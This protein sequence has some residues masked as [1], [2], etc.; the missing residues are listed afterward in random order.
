MRGGERTLICQAQMSSLVK[1]EVFTAGFSAWSLLL[2]KTSQAV[3]SHRGAVVWHRFTLKYMHMNPATLHP[4]IL[5]LYFLFTY[6][7]HS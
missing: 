7:I 4:L 6:Y 5:T 3:L 2:C 1:T